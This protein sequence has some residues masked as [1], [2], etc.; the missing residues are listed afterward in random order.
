MNAIIFISA[1]IFCAANFLHAAEKEN[2]PRLTCVGIL[3]QKWNGRNTRDYS[4]LKFYSIKEIRDREASGIPTVLFSKR[5]LSNGG[6]TTTRLHTVA[7]ADGS[8]IWMYNIPTKPG[9]YVSNWPSSKGELLKI[10]S[11]E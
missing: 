1:T 9:F 4:S 5:K 8:K 6:L 10:R 2:A 11:L 3:E 7:F